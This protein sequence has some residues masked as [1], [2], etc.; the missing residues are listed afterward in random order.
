MQDGDVESYKQIKEDQDD[1]RNLVEKSELWVY[2]SHAT[3]DDAPGGKKKKKK[4]DDD[5]DDGKNKSK[6]CPLD[7]DALWLEGCCVSLLYII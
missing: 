1:L 4:K 5:D 6:G 2:K 3:D 7:E